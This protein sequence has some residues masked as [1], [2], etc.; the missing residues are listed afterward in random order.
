M[1]EDFFRTRSRWRFGAADAQGAKSDRHGDLLRHLFHR[2]PITPLTPYIAGIN[3][4]V[5][6][7]AVEYDAVDPAIRQKEPL[8][9]PLGVCLKYG[10]PGFSEERIV[11]NIDAELV[12]RPSP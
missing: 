12:Q 9:P 8:I 1:P 6:R 11:R 2:I 5:A 10:I 3:K 4:K 7:Y